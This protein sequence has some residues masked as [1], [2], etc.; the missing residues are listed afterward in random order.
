MAR[1]FI[2]YPELINQNIIK[3]EDNSN[4]SA[5]DNNGV[6]GVNKN[7]EIIAEEILHEAKESSTSLDSL[8]KRISLY[9]YK[10]D[11]SDIIDIL[12]Q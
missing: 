9:R 5:E 7:W 4:D 12:L 3:G 11:Q 6:N 8:A 10:I 2:N 1:F